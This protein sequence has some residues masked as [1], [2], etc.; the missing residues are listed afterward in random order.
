MKKYIAALIILLMLPITVFAH[1]G[2]TDE[3]GGHW[4]GND[5]H[6]HHG[7]PEHYH[8]DMD[9]D[10]D[11]DCPYNFKDNTGS[12]SGSGS[13]FTHTDPNPST[14]VKGESTTV[15]TREV[16]PGWVQ[17]LIVCMSIAIALL[18]LSSF[19][20]VSIVRK[21]KR[22]IVNLEQK[23]KDVDSMLF[24]I[25]NLEESLNEYS[26]NFTHIYFLIKERYG[27][28]FFQDL[29]DVPK[30]V[31]FD[32][33]G[34]PS[35]TLFGKPDC[36]WGEKYT[37]YRGRY[38]FNRST[39]HTKSCRFAHIPLPVNAYTIS[40]NSLTPCTHCKPEIPDVSWIDTY[41]KLSSFIAKFKDI[42]FLKKLNQEAPR[43]EEY[44]KN[45]GRDFDMS[46]ELSEK[47]HKFNNGIKEE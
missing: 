34:L 10:G 20:I 2:R 13:K 45:I 28:G 16:V 14:F 7:Y 1:S 39:Y 9:G 21:Q 35:T 43:S 23:K 33:D 4:D 27:R 40:K 12:N 6:Y 32:R 46:A 11:I 30:H 19:F 3:I 37:F 24:E 31:Y 8:Y 47:L 29:M 26:Q 18:L 22:K 25:S 5:Y 41:K 15:V 38:N 36:P 42:E 44:F 17:P